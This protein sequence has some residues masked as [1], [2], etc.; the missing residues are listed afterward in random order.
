MWAVGLSPPEV[1]WWT[2]SLQHRQ[3]MRP[4][5]AEGASTPGPWLAAS[6][7]CGCPPGRSTRPSQRAAHLQPVGACL[8]KGAASC[9][10][11]ERHHNPRPFSDEGPSGPAGP[12]PGPARLR[13]GHR[14]RPRP[15]PPPRSAASAAAS[16]A[17]SASRAPRRCTPDGELSRRACGRQV[18]DKPLRLPS[19]IRLRG[20]RAVW[21]GVGV[22]SEAHPVAKAP[23]RVESHQVVA[24]GM[25]EESGGRLH[26]RRR[27]SGGQF[28][29]RLMTRRPGCSSRCPP[30]VPESQRGMVSQST[31]EGVAAAGACGSGARGQTNSS[32]RSEDHD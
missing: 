6:S 25:G 13:G 19:P 5:Q 20:Q 16:T 1:R 14:H 7:L 32:A 3:R 12:V 27:T 29:D 30:G 4:L 8:G 2:A 31:K 23:A 17:S 11:G 10:A 28:P 22:R 18:S 15:S 21:Q 9:L 24:V 26:H